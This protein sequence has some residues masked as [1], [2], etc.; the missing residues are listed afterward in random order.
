MKIEKMLIARIENNSAY[1]YLLSGIVK[2][3]YHVMRSVATCSF[4]VDISCTS[5]RYKSGRST[6]RLNHV[7][8][9]K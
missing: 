8:K 4:V 5:Q 7:A 6:A 3:M 9:H 2:K 1:G